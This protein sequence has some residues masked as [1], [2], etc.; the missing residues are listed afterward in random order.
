MVETRVH[1]ICD[2][3]KKEYDEKKRSFIHIVA[4]NEKGTNTVVSFENVEIK[5]P[6]GDFCSMRCVTEEIADQINK[7]IRSP[8]VSLD[9]AMEKAMGK[10][11]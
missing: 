5:M 4:D 1:M 8:F 6:V 7:K 2:H 9:K 3:C 11:E 10:Q